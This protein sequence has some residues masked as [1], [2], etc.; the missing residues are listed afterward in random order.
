VGYP[1]HEKSKDP[2]FLSEVAEIVPFIL[3]GILIIEQAGDG[4]LVLRIFK[5]EAKFEY[6]GIRLWVFI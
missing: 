1:A 6:Q 4:W 3:K 2:Y 5:I